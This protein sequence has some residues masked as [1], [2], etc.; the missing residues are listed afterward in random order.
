MARKLPA[1]DYATQTGW[2]SNS[3]RTRWSYRN[4]LGGIG[5]IIKVSVKT[6]ST[7]GRVQFNATGRNGGYA[8]APTGIPVRVTFA[9]DSAAGQCGE[10]PFAGPPPSPSCSFSAG[11]LSCK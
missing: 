8:V 11:V 3:S 7:P 5:G 6:S 9:V 10:A 2:K 4:G 1:Y